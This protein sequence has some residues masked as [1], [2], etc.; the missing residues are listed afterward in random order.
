M[1]GIKLRILKLRLKNKALR[2]SS[3]FIQNIHH[4]RDNALEDVRPPIEK[5]V[6]FDEAQRAWNQEQTSSF[7][8]TGKGVTVWSI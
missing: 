2:E 7:M 4:F 5:V 8:R 6:V 3:T 1:P